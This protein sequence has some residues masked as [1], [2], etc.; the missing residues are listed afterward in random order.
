MNKFIKGTL[1]GML[2]LVLL[3]NIVFAHT[4]NFYD[5]ET[6]L[7][8]KEVEDGDN[9]F[10]QLPN[11]SSG[12]YSSVNWFYDPEFTRSYDQ[13]DAITSDVDVYGKFKANFFFRT[14]NEDGNENSK[15]GTIYRNNGSN[16]S[17]NSATSALP[18]TH[19]VLT[20]EPKPGFVFVEWRVGTTVSA[21]P[22]MDLDTYSTNTQ[23]EFDIAG[24]TTVWAVFAQDLDARFTLTLDPNNGTSETDSYANREYESQVQLS[25]PSSYGFTT[26]SHKMFVDWVIDGEH[27]NAGEFYTIIKDATAVA[28]WRNDDTPLYTVTFNTNGGSTIDPVQ[29]YENEKLTKPEDPTI[30]GFD[31]GKWYTDEGLTQEYDFDSLVNG[32]FTLYASY[33]G[34][35]WYRTIDASTG[36]IS[37]NVGTITAG[38]SSTSGGY[39]TLGLKGRTINVYAEAKTGY[40]FVEWRIGSNT[41][42]NT[43]AYDDLEP[44]CYTEECSFEVDGHMT[45]MA[46]FA[47]NGPVGDEVISYAFA[48]VTNPFDG[49]TPSTVVESSDP[50]VYDVEFVSWYNLTDSTST[51]T[52]FVGGKEYEYRIRFV[53]REG[54]TFDETTVFYINGQETSSYG[55]IADRQIYFTAGEPEPVYEVS[56]NYNGGVDSEGQNGTTIELVGFV[57]FVTEDNFIS[58]F[59]SQMYEVT[60]PEGMVFDGI[61]VDGVK[62]DIGDGIEINRNMTIFYQW[63]PEQIPVSIDYGYG[64]TDPYLVQVEYGE[65]VAEPTEV[66]ERPGFIFGGWVNAATNAPYDFS[67]PVY[68]ELELVG[69]WVE[70]GTNITISFDM[71]GS[72]EMD[73]VTVEAGTVVAKPADPV[74]NDPLRFVFGGWYLDEAYEK[75]FDFTKPVTRNTMLHAKWNDRLYTLTFETNGGN[76]I[77]SRKYRYEEIPTEVIPVKENYTF[78]G[79]YDSAELTHEYEYTAIQADITIYAKWQKNN[80]VI[81]IDLNGGKKNGQPTYTVEVPE[82]SYALDKNEIMRGVVA[83]TGKEL[84]YVTVN[85]VKEQF[86][87]WVNINSTNTIKLFWKDS[88]PHLDAFKVSTGN[89]TSITLTWNRTNNAT[90]YVLYQSLNNKKWSKVTTISNGNTL[91]YIKT[92]L[93]ANKTYYYKMEAYKGSTRLVISKVLK[94]K[95][96]PK[97]PTLTVKTSTYNSVTLNIRKVTG[98][99]KYVLERSTDNKTF[100]AVKTVS[101]AGK[102]TDSGLATNTKY[103]YRVKACSTFCSGYSKVKNRVPEFKKPTIRVTAGKLQAKVKITKVTGAQGYVIERSTAKKSGYALVAYTTSLTY[104]DNKNIVSKKSYYYRI[105]AY[106]TINGKKV[107]SAYSAVKKVKVK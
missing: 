72:G 58:G 14:V 73:D 68:E 18:N 95:T 76:A 82:D 51:V 43:I 52:T 26:P 100:K 75:E 28:Q 1:L 11:V 54:Y 21:Y 36:D 91:K 93:T 56:L 89:T 60:P 98:A 66:P 74:H 81:T 88:R 19:I 106:R 9:L 96:A 42:A 80:N 61:K 104:V 16:Y 29:V 6:L 12:N 46:V 53:P 49:E 27:Y 32:N 41:V 62:Y 83:P 70:E 10:G 92:K 97:A 30:T 85:G 5:G 86:G 34:N 15:Y 25:A 77:E 38:A 67:S 57:P 3:P 44:T 69:V 23:I 40:H 48:M 33:R 65:T 4:V 87:R 94:T 17:G 84:D 35:I 102:V 2:L 50:E 79:W 63:A 105:R 90:S 47:Q 78:L 22:F 107:Y 103:Y 39:A 13:S 59:T 31:F 99:T 45:V 55:T 37:R 24:D 7:A 71:H 101:K 64:S 8:T 20:V